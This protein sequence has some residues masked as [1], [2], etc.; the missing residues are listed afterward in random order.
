MSWS[1]PA[2]SASWRARSCCRF[3]SPAYARPHRCGSRSRHRGRSRRAGRDW[4]RCTSFLE[5]IGPLARRH[6]VTRSDGGGS[7]R[8]SASSAGT[9]DQNRLCRQASRSQL[10]AFLPTR[11]RSVARI[12]EGACASRSEAAGSTRGRSLL[13]VVPLHVSD[14]H[15]SFVT[16]LPG[17]KARFELGH[18]RWHQQSPCR[19]RAFLRIDDIDVAPR[20]ARIVGGRLDPRDDDLVIAHL[21]RRQVASDRARSALR[22]IQIVLQRVPFVGEANDEDACRAAGH[23]ARRQHVQHRRGVCLQ[24]HVTAI[25]GDRRRRRARVARPATGAGRRRH[26]RG[27]RAR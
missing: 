8:P 3:C 13:V 18:R 26:T 20:P 5:K 10:A 11:W 2:R 27:P 15:V 9:N 12:A 14:H 4:R 25:E 19:R 7:G 6:D 24:R 23:H 21:A 1:L 22:Q 17:M 16:G